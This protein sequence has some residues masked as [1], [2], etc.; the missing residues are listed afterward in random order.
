MKNSVHFDLSPEFRT[1]LDTL[2]SRDRMEILSKITQI[3]SIGLQVS[4]SK[5]WVKKIGQN[6]YE[7]RIR[8]KFNSQRALYFHLTKS[9]Y[10]IVSGFTK[11]TQKTPRREIKRAKSIRNSYTKG[12]D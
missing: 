11:K 8:T 4:I 6:L 10:I 2:N 7:I 3:E 12:K 5:K 9:Q 1:F